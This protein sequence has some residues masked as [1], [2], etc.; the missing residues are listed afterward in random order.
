MTAAA[1]AVPG[2]DAEA[3]PP[4][5]GGKKRLIV[6]LALPLLLGGAG[7]G[8]WFGGILP[9]L[10]GMAA[11]PEDK[12]AGEPAPGQ[13]AP[14]QAAQGQA[15]SGQAAPGTGTG[16]GAAGDGKPVARLAPVF[17]EIPEI[18]ANLNAGP[19]RSSFIKLRAK[20]ELSRAE[21]EIAVRAAMPRLLYLFQTYLREMRPEELRGSAGTYRLREELIARAN[22]AVAPARILDVL[23]PEIIV[24]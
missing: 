5:R 8:L 21:D 19:R 4:T 1:V 10:L 17:M 11:K 24:Q 22:I 12:S 23:F 15:T 2:D 13:A 16:A 7:A 3:A 20:L 18:I 9:P 14:G 6:L